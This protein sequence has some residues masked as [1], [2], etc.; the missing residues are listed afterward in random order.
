MGVGIFSGV[1]IF[2]RDY[3]TGIPYFEFSNG[4]NFC[5]FHMKPQDTKIKNINILNFKF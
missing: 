1:G 2:L 3:S 4:A 5:I